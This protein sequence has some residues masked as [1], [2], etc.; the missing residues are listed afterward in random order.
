MLPSRPDLQRISG[1]L[2]VGSTLPHTKFYLLRLSSDLEWHPSYFM[3]PSLF[4]SHTTT[5]ILAG[6]AEAEGIDWNKTKIYFADERCVPLDHSD[7]SAMN[8]QQHNSTLWGRSLSAGAIGLP[9]LGK[10]RGI[11]PH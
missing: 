11:L 4:L 6:L 9:S 7:R 8:L 2:H 5:Q 1:R 10:I 3:P